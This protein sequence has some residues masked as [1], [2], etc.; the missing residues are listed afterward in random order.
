MR[1][2]LEVLIAA[3]VLVGAAVLV[4]VF[5]LMIHGVPYDEWVRLEKERYEMKRSR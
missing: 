5:R 3:L 4:M 2:F 1:F